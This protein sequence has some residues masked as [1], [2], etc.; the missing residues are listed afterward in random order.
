MRFHS[1]VA[2]VAGCASTRAVEIGHIQALEDTR[3]AG[4]LP[5][6]LRHHDSELRARAALAL[7]RIADPATFPALRAAL[8]DSDASVVDAAEFA[9]GIAQDL[10]AESAL[11]ALPSSPM[12]DFALGQIGG[13]ATLAKNPS[14]RVLLGFAVRGAPVDDAARGSLARTLAGPD[15]L[16]AAHCLVRLT[17]AG[18][19]APIARALE[20]AVA[21]S[22][23]EV[24]AAAVR[25]LGKW[26][27]DAT[28][29]FARALGDAAVGVR[30]QAVRA[31][32]AGDSAAVNRHLEQ[33]T[34]AAVLLAGLEAL[35]KD[36][37]DRLLSH[38]EAAIRCRAYVLRGEVP[39]D[40]PPRLRAK[41][42][43]DETALRVLWQEPNLRSA[44]AE[45]A[46]EL[47]LTAFVRDMLRTT[48]EGV[49]SAAAEGL[50]ATPE[51]V[52]ALL[53]ALDSLRSETGVEA[54]LAIVDTLAAIGDKQAVASLAALLFDP[55]AT[56][57]ARATGALEKMGVVVPRVKAARPN[58]T[59]G[60]RVV[61]EA[62]STLLIARVETSRGSFD[63]ALNGQLAPHTVASFVHLARQR[64]F[65]G[66]TFHRVV[67]DFVVQ[68]GDP[69][70]DGYG[71]PGFTLRCE[72]TP[73][74]YVRGT[75][76]MALAG[77][78]TGGSQWFVTLSAQ[79]HLEG[80]YTVFGRVV[81]GMEV[82][83]ALLPGDR[84]I[85]VRV[86]N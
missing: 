28:S 2:I 76:G 62:A 37:P 82:V 26:A 73:S 85:R 86:V 7:G 65:D 32:A 49:L 35:T 78:D 61:D 53:Q 18:N 72:L 58:P 80:R 11:T 81:L 14:P 67:P 54:M 43:Q 41:V 17:P 19:I 64:F 51:A 33:E 71:G 27:P 68:G 24:R 70:G 31:L 22:D 8:L 50:K 25:A 3:E 20:L 42:A 13:A 77:K 66:T 56:V 29:I 21:D 4:D 63:I 83:D 75:V 6:L 1:L 34:N 5:S 30:V 36:P 23:S 48:D 39:S 47:G 10:G 79:P 60:D 40:C 38:P 16:L 12:R 52:P 44:V 46:A 69:R 45:R 15:R 74:A 57:R 84:I 9:L 59:P 55:N